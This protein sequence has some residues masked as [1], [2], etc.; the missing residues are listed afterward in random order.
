MIESSIISLR[1]RPS[2]W[3][4][5]SLV[6]KQLAL[7]SPASPGLLRGWKTGQLKAVL[8]DLLDA[9]LLDI[10]AGLSNKQF[11][12]TSGVSRSLRQLALAIMGLVFRTEANGLRDA[13]TFVPP[14][15]RH[16][17]SSR[18]ISCML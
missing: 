5:Q 8:L 11:R 9:D 13:F 6:C 7:P 16:A 18:L 4:S 17:V 3:S 15:G 1:D 14:A 10:I 2:S 12:R